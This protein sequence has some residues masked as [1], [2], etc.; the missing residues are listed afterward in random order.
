MNEAVIQRFA[1][2]ML[3]AMVVVLAAFTAYMCGFI[4]FVCFATGLPWQAMLDVPLAALMG[5]IQL[6]I[7]SVARSFR[8]GP[9]AT[10]Q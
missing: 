6:Y 1:S 8:R 3:Y 2:W 10:A 7:F 9:V 4:A 5:L